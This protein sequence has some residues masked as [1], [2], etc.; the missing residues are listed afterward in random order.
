MKKRD[1]PAAVSIAQMPFWSHTCGLAAI[2]CT[3]S[4]YIPVITNLT[5]FFSVPRQNAL[6]SLWDFLVHSLMQSSTC[7]WSSQLLQTRRLAYGPG[8]HP[9]K[10]EQAKML[11]I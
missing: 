9:N 7:N 2:W 3:T 8:P 4:E 11:S 5:Y 10:P 6:L 1:A